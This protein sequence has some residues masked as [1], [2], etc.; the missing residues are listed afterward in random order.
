[1]NMDGTERPKFGDGNGWEYRRVKI[2]GKDY[3]EIVAFPPLPS[4]VA[5]IWYAPDHLRAWRRDAYERIGGHAP[6]RV[7]DDLDLMCRLFQEGL[8]YHIDKPLYIYRVHGGN[9]WLRYNAEIQSNVPRIFEQYIERMALK[10]AYQCE[11]LALDLGGRFNRAKGFKSVDLHDADFIANLNLRWPFDDGSVGVVR[12]YDVF[13]HLS[14]SIHTMK[15]LFRVLAPNGIAC[16]QVPSTDGRGAF[17]DPTHVSFWNENSMLYYTN[18]Q[19]AKYIDV[20]VRFQN[21]LTYTTKPDANGVCW[22]RSFLLKLDE[23]HEH[24][25]PGPINI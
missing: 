19:W 25:P 17:Q 10:W 22:V 14:D 13:E 11:L 8:F 3:N 24:R 5:R 18:I 23:D 6:M 1:M 20:P 7:L 2:D 4:S 15:E 9:T 16:I 12:A 21:L